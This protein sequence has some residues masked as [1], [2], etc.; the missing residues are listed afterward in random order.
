MHCILASCE[1][2][3]LRINIFFAHAKFMQEKDIFLPNSI[4]VTVLVS[5][6]PAQQDF[7]QELQCLGIEETQSAGTATIFR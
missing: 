3:N 7:I 6:E 4:R 1:L 2:Q 5:E